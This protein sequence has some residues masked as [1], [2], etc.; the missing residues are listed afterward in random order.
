MS[1]RPCRLLSLLALGALAACNSDSTR[2]GSSFVV[3]Q[4]VKVTGAQDLKL[5]GG[6]DGAEFFAVLVNTGITAGDIESYTLSGNGIAQPTLALVPP[7]GASL[8]RLIDGDATG[9]PLPDQAFESRLRARERALLTPRIT[10]ARAWLAARQR[11]SRSAAGTSIQ[12][13][14]DRRETALPS[15]VRVGDTVTVNVNGVDACDNPTNHGA[16]VVAIGTHSIVLADTAN[17]A[18]GFTDADYQRYATRFDTLVYPVDVG[19]FGAPTDIDGN[20]RVAL[21]FTSEVNKLTPP[22]ADAY[23]G[24]FTF[25]RDLFPIVGNQFGGSCPSSN[26]GE[27]FYLL[28]PDP[29]GTINGNK[30][31][32]GFVDTNTTA[33][34]AHEFQHLINA[35]RRMYVNTAD[36]FE[37]T[38]LDEGLSH[39]AE[40]LLFYHEAG[41]SPRNNLDTLD[42]RSTEIRRGSFNLDMLGNAGRYRSYLLAPSTSSPYAENDS[43]STRGAAWSLL[44]YLADHKASSDGNI[45]SQLVN[46][47]TTG[48]ANVTAVF[49]SAFPS[50]VRDWSVSN[51]VDDLVDSESDLQQPSWNWRSIHKVLYG[52]YPLDFQTMSPGE[53]YNGTVTAGGAAY[54]RLA[55]RAGSSATLSLGGRSA[56]AG[57]KLQFVVVRIR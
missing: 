24:G 6:S 4:S 17:P 32:A 36:D 27:Y 1:A 8:S 40:E 38:W 25:S 20:G 28:T 16:R 41:L 18:N 15:S 50:L 57:S 21:I 11:A 35:S 26:E 9:A 46:S 29:L 3:G 31:T 12:V 53:S 37:E 56:S 52:F 7:R 51:A 43:L 54:Y 33:V 39:I 44:R 42:L 45:F 48:I 47:K 10:G 14:R 30:R 49:G 34:I 23:V 19:A 2:P 5:D 55:V 22:D 13:P